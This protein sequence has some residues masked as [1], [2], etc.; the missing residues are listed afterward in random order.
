MASSGLVLLPAEILALVVSHLSN[1]DVKSLRLTCKR[2]HAK[3]KLRLDR[4][5]LSANPRDVQVFRAVADDDTFRHGIVEII[6]DDAVIQDTAREH[7]GTEYNVYE[8]DEDE[9]EEYPGVPPWFSRACEKN[10][11]E[12]RSRYID[13]VLD[14]PERALSA[15]L[16]VHESWERFQEWRAEQRR[17]I[18]T[19]A[20]VAA[21]RYGLARFPSLR[22]IT[23]TPSMHGY[24]IGHPLYDTPAIRS[25]PPGFNYP[26]PRGW[27]TAG[28]AEPP[29]EMLPWA[30]EDGGTEAY[31]DRWHGFR[32]VLREL[33][34]QTDS[35]RVLELN[36]D[37]HQLT[38]GINCRIFESPNP[39]YD[40]F[41]SLLRQPGFRRLDLALSVG[42]QEHFGWP[43]FRSALLKRAL[44][45]IGQDLTHVSLSTDVDLDI[46]DMEWIDD[47]DGHHIPLLGAI[48][49]VDRWPR[50]C[51]FGL[52]R[53]LVTRADLLSLLAALPPTLRS[54]ELGNLKFLD[55]GG[56]W[57]GLLEDI[58]D[59]L[60]WR[61]RPAQDRPRVTLHDAEIDGERRPGREVWL[62]A[63]VAEF[64]YRNGENP[65]GQSGCH[66]GQ[67]DKGQGGVVRDAF[68]PEYERPHV[69]LGELSRLGYIK[70]NF[71]R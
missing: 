5:F 21:F 38:T 41:V 70:G 36:L 69:I 59:C 37:A 66:R 30:D 67:I 14:R 65:F 23:V 43:A 34:K 32:I 18:T 12:L 29:V 45:K 56:H 20:D 7:D 62:E 61:D 55:E 24:N 68:D 31:R 53:F 2:V 33:A 8:A 58:R 64:L 47:P 63:A 54:V 50:L 49:P 35:Q 46:P 17:V 26:L 52:S 48:F 3:T 13:D 40:Q 51:H 28:E 71:Q 11:F 57:R 1:N 6:W 19:G 22:T 27:P 4:V 16:P 9:E 25:F 42:A 10:N 60:E 44:S 39:E 15:Q